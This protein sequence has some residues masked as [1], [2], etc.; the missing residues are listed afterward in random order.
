MP[1]T[2][3]PG[4]DLAAFSA[5]D[6]ADDP[7]ALQHYLDQAKLQPTLQ[8]LRPKMIEQLRL[9]RPARLLDAGCGLGTEAM[10][11][12]RAGEVDV[13]GIDNSLAMIEEARR[14]V[15]GTGLPI[16]FSPADA[17]DLPFP[18][19]HF[20]ACQAQTL[21][22]HIADPVPV[23]SELVRVTRP[24]G[25][26]VLLDLDQGSTLLDHPDRAT[27]RI[28]MQALTDSFANGWAGR[29]LRR[30]L[31]QAGTHEVTVELTTMDLHPAFLL[32]LLLPTMRRLQAD[33]VTDQATLDRWW[34]E[35]EDLAQSGLFSASTTWFLAAGTIP[36]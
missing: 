15:S 2:T 10:E 31:L 16:S 11:L 6:A 25:R 7:Q 17:T 3:G 22:G 30:L 13:V 34:N 21:L 35:L 4:L 36:H 12:A 9:P 32:Q 5:V 20:D 33:N 26:V 19:N 18:D 23:L 1:Q 29:Q 24:C 28:V 8:A 27:T 14:R